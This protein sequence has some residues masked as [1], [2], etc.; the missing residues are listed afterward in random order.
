ML[1]IW[2]MSVLIKTS[3]AG[4]L[5]KRWLREIRKFSAYILL[6]MGSSKKTSSW[7]LWNV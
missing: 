4:A 2:R 7:L 3:S 1:Y 6:H 5:N